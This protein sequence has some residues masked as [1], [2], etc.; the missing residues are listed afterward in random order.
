MCSAPDAILLQPQAHNKLC[1]RFRLFPFSLAA[2]KGMCFA[3]FEN[4]RNVVF[5][6]SAY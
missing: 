6:S 1:A 5:F 4:L 2:T 3:K